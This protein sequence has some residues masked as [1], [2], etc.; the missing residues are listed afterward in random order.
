MIASPRRPE[1]RMEHNASGAEYGL[2]KKVEGL[3]QQ[4]KENKS[5]GPIEYKSQIPPKPEDFAKEIKGKKVVIFLAHGN[6][7]EGI[8]TDN[9]WHF[10]GT[11]VR[12]TAEDVEAALKLLKDEEKPEA[13]LIVGCKQWDPSGGKS[14]GKSFKAGGI[15]LVVASSEQVN[16][17]RANTPGKSDNAGVGVDYVRQALDQLASGDA[18]ETAASVA[19]EAA[20]QTLQS[21]SDIKGRG[22]P[23]PLPDPDA[24]DGNR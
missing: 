4:I 16:L 3:N 24:Q 5:G 15:P 7:E 12:L 6:P 1:F 8:K 21:Y 19:A 17:E 14:V 10:P 20:R 22:V 11:D 23:E 13:V 9:D 18:P 2:P